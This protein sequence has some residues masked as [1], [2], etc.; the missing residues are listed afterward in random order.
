MRKIRK[1]SFTL[2]EILVAMAV[3]SILLT[4][5]VQFFASART[6]WT[7]N[8]K[9]TSVYADASIAMNLMSALLQTTFYSEAGTEFGTPFEITNP[10]SSRPAT[11]WNSSLMFV[12]NSNMKLSDS[13]TIRY[14][15]FKRG[16]GN[17]NDPDPG[18]NR[19]TVLQLRIF[20]D[21]D[22][23]FAQC[24]QPFGTAPLP[25]DGTEA[26]ARTRI[27]NFLN[28]TATDAAHLKP[29]LRN[30]TGLRFIPLNRSG[31]QSGTTATRTPVAIEIELSLMADQATAE[32]WAGMTT[33]QAKDDFRTKNEYT[34]R[35]TV[36]L[37]DRTFNQ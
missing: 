34:F 1:N 35:R 18:N 14:L 30:V 12:S 16:T 37:G 24:F 22:P 19:P 10:D 25:L 2:V 9:R 23:D 8:E 13:G 28:N 31:A 21:T 15:M 11:G 27:N 29:I 36:W 33:G 7:A 4:L 26:G 17:H 32:E 6:L 3:F 5:M 20:C